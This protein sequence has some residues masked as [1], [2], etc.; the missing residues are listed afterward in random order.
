MISAQKAMTRSCHSEAVH[1]LLSELVFSGPLMILRK[2]TSLKL[3]LVYSCGTLSG[4]RKCQLHVL[5]TPNTGE[6]TYYQNPRRSTLESRRGAALSLCPSALAEDQTF[7]HSIVKRGPLY[8]SRVNKES[9]PQRW[10]ITFR[11]RAPSSTL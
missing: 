4:Y 11:N 10:C 7:P 9:S 1:T 5:P 6:A 8:H 2:V 3:S